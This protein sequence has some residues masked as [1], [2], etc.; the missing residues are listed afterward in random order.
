M[1]TLVVSFFV[2]KLYEYCFIGLYVDMCFHFSWEILKSRMSTPSGE[3]MVNFIRNFQTV[4]QDDYLTL[5]F[6]NN[7]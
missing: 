2:V 6:P 1:D 7:V 3:Y 5:Y 4:F